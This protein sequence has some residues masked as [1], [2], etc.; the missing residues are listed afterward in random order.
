MRQK[1]IKVSN[2][3]LAVVTLSLSLSACSNS[4]SKEAKKISINSTTNNKKSVQH[5]HPKNECINAV[6]HAHSKGELA[7]KH[8]YH[9]CKANKEKSNAHIHPA[10]KY[11]KKFRHVHSN[12]ANKHSHHN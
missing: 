4:P 8:Y 11:S 6:T 2:I 1:M 10:T 12:G 3:L 9:H 5:T 7:H